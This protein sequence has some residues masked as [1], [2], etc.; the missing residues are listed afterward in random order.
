MD[1]ETG[2][3]SVDQPVTAFVDRPNQ[4]GPI[5]YDK[6]ALFF[7]N[8]RDKLGDQV[9]FGALASYYSAEHYKIASPADLLGAFESSCSCD[10]SAFYAQWGVE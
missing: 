7:V 8:L 2:D 1:Q 9:F 5:V 4:Y 10:L 3:T 6:G